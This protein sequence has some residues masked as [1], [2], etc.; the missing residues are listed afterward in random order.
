MSAPEDDTLPIAGMF[1]NEGDEEN[2]KPNFGK[3]FRCPAQAVALDDALILRN[4]SAMPTTSSMTK[5][6]PTPTLEL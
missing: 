6:P 1:G 4:N 5:A 3:G 2:Q